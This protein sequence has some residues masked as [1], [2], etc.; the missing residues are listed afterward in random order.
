MSCV[1]EPNATTNAHHTTGSRATWGSKQAMPANP[2][3]T[4]LLHELNPT[5]AGSVI[6]AG[7]DGTAILFAIKEGLDAV[8]DGGGQ[9]DFSNAGARTFLLER[10]G[11]VFDR[12]V[13]SGI[14]AFADM[15]PPD[16]EVGKLTGLILPTLEELPAD[17]PTLDRFWSG[18]SFVQQGGRA[19]H[20]AIVRGSVLP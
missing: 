17:G 10:I 9:I 8:A 2:A 19:L 7:Q 20:G 13:A 12:A 11:G 3:M 4:T 16:E 18:I 1:A 6:D 15:T 5:L 14:L